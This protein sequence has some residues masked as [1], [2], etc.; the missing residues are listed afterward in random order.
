MNYFDSFRDIAKENEICPKCLKST[1]P[2]Y[3]KYNWSCKCNEE[4]LGPP[5]TPSQFS[6]SQIKPE[7]P[8]I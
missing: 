5:S 4:E 3:T 8:P 6:S 1:R 7:N 2:E